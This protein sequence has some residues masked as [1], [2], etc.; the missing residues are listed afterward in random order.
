MV[1]GM[2]LG[3]NKPQPEGATFWRILMIDKKC[4][5]C[6][7]T[8]RVTPSR[9]PNA[10][11]CCMKCQ[12]EYRKNNP[13]THPSCRK[14]VAITCQYCNTVFYVIPSLAK[15]RKSCSRHCQREYSKRQRVSLACA[16]CG[17]IFI[18]DPH[19]KETA[20]FCS[21]KCHNKYMKGKPNPK[22]SLALSGRR[23]PKRIPK[24]NLIK[25]ICRVATKIGHTPSS[26]DYREHGNYDH[27]TIYTSFNNWKDAIEQSG[28]DYAQME[29]HIS[30]IRSLAT[31]KTWKDNDAYRE[32]HCQGNHWRWAGGCQTWRGPNWNN[33]S[34]RARE[35]DNYC[36]QS[37]GVTQSELGKKLDVHHIQPFRE[38]GF[39]PYKNKNYIQANQIDNLI[40]LCPSCHQKTEHSIR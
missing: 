3:H 15:K 35:R 40:T 4:I 2:L 17:D 14:K 9:A 13:G 36:C 39:V 37:C 34:E 20:K 21:V 16:H 10:K 19:R 11:S 23:S 12:T 25:D 7:K 5:N 6:G 38:F 32:S 8:F 1:Y 26:V 31:K 33:Q 30:E 24:E 28:L 22:A 18:V 27:S 29:R